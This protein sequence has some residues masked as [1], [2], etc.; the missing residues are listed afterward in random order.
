MAAQGTGKGRLGWEE[1]SGGSRRCR[2]G[3]GC[4]FPLE[5]LLGVSVGSAAYQL[6][7]FGQVEVGRLLGLGEAK[8][9]EASWGPAQELQIGDG[10][11]ELLRPGCLCSD[12]APSS[13]SRRRW[14]PHFSLST[15][16]ESAAWA[17]IVGLWDWWAGG[18]GVGDAPEQNRGGR[19]GV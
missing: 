13:G 19:P 16:L 11:C 2:G 9:A 8:S 17:G 6:G 4:G 7:G 1:A 18:G 12:P 10:R 15:N 5:A 14:L 3:A